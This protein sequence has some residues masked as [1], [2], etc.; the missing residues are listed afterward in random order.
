M[1]S[2]ERDDTHRRD[3]T[4]KLHHSIACIMIGFSAVAAVAPSEARAERII[5]IDLA[6]S[7][8]L[9]F[10][11][12]S[13]QVTERVADF[14]SACE[15]LRDGLA[16]DLA[17]TTVR[18]ARRQLVKE[19]KQDLKDARDLARDEIIA[20]AIEIKAALSVHPAG[21]A[22][23]PAID[24]VRN[25]ALQQVNDAFKSYNREFQSMAR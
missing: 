15:G 8:S 14:E 12:Y 5:N 1:V 22:L 10:G 21:V 16:S 4:M 13:G 18:S 6:V 19:A 3:R 17:G 23:F 7:A 9:R 24:D 25:G 2:R 11:L 20:L